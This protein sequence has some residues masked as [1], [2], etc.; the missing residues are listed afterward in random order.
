M[1]FP[2]LVFPLSLISRHTLLTSSI[3]LFFWPIQLLFALFFIACSL[4]GLIIKPLQMHD[5]FLT[6]IFL[7]K[8]KGKPLFFSQ[9]HHS[10][11]L[12]ELLLSSGALR[13]RSSQRFAGCSNCVSLVLTVIQASY[14]G[15]AISK[16]SP[17]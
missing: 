12:C 1:P 17:E 8:V 13:D 3:I 14:T 10:S 11:F 15:H 5:F 7:N 2:A 6:K 16:L 4:L 9:L